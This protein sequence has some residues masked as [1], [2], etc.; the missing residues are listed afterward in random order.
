[1]DTIPFTG[2]PHLPNLDLGV[3]LQTPNFQRLS[4]SAFVLVGRDENFFEWAGGRIII[5]NVDLAWRPTGQL[6]TEVIYDHQQV[7]RPDDGSNVSLIRV[8]RLKIEYQLARPIFLRLIGQYTSNETDALRD[9][10]RTNG[11]ILIRNPVTG[12]FTRTVPT[13][14]NAFRIDWLFSYHSTPGTVGY[15]GYGNSMQEPT[16]FRFHRLSRVNDGFFAKLSYLFR[17]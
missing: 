13:A 9:D 11:A 10:S 8:P 16:A 5:G 1:M 12:A 3:N 2:T 14:S 6:R 7:I 15:V 17:L 4:L